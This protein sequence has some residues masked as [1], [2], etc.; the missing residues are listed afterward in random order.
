MEIEIIPG[1]YIINIGV[2]SLVEII[3]VYEITQSL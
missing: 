3:Y 1:K 2:I